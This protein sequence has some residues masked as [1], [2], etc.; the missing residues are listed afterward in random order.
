[1]EEAEED[2]LEV[3]WVDI[4]CTSDDELKLS[5]NIETGISKREHFA[6]DD[7]EGGCNEDLSKLKRLQSDVEGMLFDSTATE[8][9]KNKFSAPFVLSGDSLFIRD[10]VLKSVCVFV[11]VLD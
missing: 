5:K 2:W 4:C 8:L 10:K 6:G 1:M 11:D 9:N 7:D 3:V